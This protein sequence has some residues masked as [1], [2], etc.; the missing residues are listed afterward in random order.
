[1][2]LTVLDF[3]P[4]KLIN[5]FITPLIHAVI[6]YVHLGI[7]D[8]KETEALCRE[9]LNGDVHNFLVAHSAIFQVKLIIGKHE[10]RV[11]SL[12]TLDSPWRIDV[13]NLKVSNL[14]DQVLQ[15]EES[16]ITV[17]ESIRAKFGLFTIVFIFCIPLVL[18]HNFGPGLNRDI[19][20]NQLL[21]WSLLITLFNA[22]E[23]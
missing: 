19:Q 5:D 11:I 4:S 7:E 12:G 1:M 22:L 9:I 17:D 16:E 21:F 20:S 6:S 23:V 14:V 15:I 3:D 13:N 2:D 8:P 18:S 10:T